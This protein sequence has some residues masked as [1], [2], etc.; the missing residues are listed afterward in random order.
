MPG[1]LP[2]GK[3]VDKMFVF[4]REKGTGL[5]EARHPPG[6]RGRK[7]DDVVLR[8]SVADKPAPLGHRFAMAQAPVA[9]DLCNTD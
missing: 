5:I 8:Y 7:S 6:R 9:M 2:I 4:P 1:P 3:P